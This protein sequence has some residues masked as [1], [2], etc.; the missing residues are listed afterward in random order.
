M[1]IL[2]HN[3]RDTRVNDIEARDAL[4]KKYD[5]MVVEVRNAI[6]D[7]NAGPG[8]ATYL[9]NASIDEWILLS[10]SNEN[11]VSFE[12]EEL[13][14]SNGQVTTKYV[15]VD[16]KIWG[17]K[18]IKGDVIIAEPRE[19]DVTVSGTTISGLSE[20]NGNKIRFVYAYGSMTAQF[21]QYVDTKISE[22]NISTSD[23]IG[24]VSDFE[25][26]LI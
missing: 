25:A 1:A 9:Y 5:H 13:V 17:L 22:I 16:H 21:S 2:V 12:L 15:P 4:A 19:E 18:I 8:P 23:N 26:S 3:N 14:I 7:V 24:T 10:K 11:N 6:S 20:F